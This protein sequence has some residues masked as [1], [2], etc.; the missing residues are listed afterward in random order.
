[1]TAVADKWSR[2][3]VSAPFGC[4]L[5]IAE[6]EQGNEG[7]MQM[8]PSDKINQAFVDGPGGTTALQVVKV[9]G[10]S[11]GETAWGGI[12]GTLDDQTDL[13]A[14]LAAKADDAHTHAYADLTDP[15]V[16]GDAAALDVGIIAGTVAAGDHTHP[17]GSEAFPVGSG[18]IS[19]VST[20]P[21]TLLGYG[22][23][24]QK[25]GGRLL[26]GQTD[27]DPDFDTAEETGGSKTSTALLAHTHTITDPGHTHTQDAHTHT[28]NAHNHVI[29]SQT[30]TT[31]GATSYEHGT[32]DTSSAEA[33]A[34]EVTAN[35][36]AV[37]QN[38]TAVNQSASTGITGAN[39]AGSGASFS[40]MNPYFV[41]YIWKRVS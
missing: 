9:G 39:S 31:G 24:E 38:A 34:T 7:T 30:A 12:T 35:A 14:V 20:N 22:T 33:E 1:M 8:G 21:A 13:Q 16:L 6:V 28:Q 26:V 36:T 3:I 19:F 40:L 17:G 10:T 18:F 32:L 5:Q 2:A 4:A 41:V 15:P 37:N 23:W 27:A 11:S 29:T 25:A